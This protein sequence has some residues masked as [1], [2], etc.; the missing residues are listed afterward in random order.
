[1]CA[2]FHC[3]VHM[4]TWSRKAARDLRY[5][6]FRARRRRAPFFFPPKG[7]WGAVCGVAGHGRAPEKVSAGGI[8]TS[9]PRRTCPSFFPNFS[10]RSS[11][12]AVGAR[13]SHLGGRKAGADGCTGAARQLAPGAKGCARVPEDLE[14]LPYFFCRPQK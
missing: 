5:R 9:G 3:V 12:A 6:F 7:W 2:V 14:D 11:P 8:I 10:V 4:A 1:V 13:A